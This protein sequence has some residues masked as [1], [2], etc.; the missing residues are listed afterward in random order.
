M[1]VVI[2]GGSG[3][4]GSFVSNEL[5]DRDH[6]V[7][8]FDLQE[9]EYVSDAEFRKGDVTDPADIAAAVSDADAVV[10]MVSM[11]G[12][13][14]EDD[15]VAALNV[16]V[17]GPVNVLE[18]TKNTDTR[19]IYISS[20]A[21]FGPITGEHSHP[22]YLPLQESVEKN[23]EQ[24]YGITKL[25]AEH[26]CK[27]YIRKYDSDVSIFR[28]GTTYGPY[29]GTE[30]HSISFVD[31]L[32]EQAIDGE[33]IELSGGDQRED[34]IYHADIARGLADALEAERLHYPSYH[35]GSGSLSTIRDFAD[36]LTD[37]FP[38]ASFEIE[39]GTD[40]YGGERN[41]YAFMDISRARADFG[42]DPKYSIREGLGD[43]LRRRGAI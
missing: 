32:V 15:P 22:Q 37:H 14:C 16:N 3:A 35:L 23:P 18:A 28:F 2:T 38:D 10:H 31:Q 13:A 1:D 5:L 11:L 27:S 26:Y 29:K 30:R 41:Y 24:L 7:T 36:V 4:I 25:A 33:T 21:A 20:K 6:D 19:V 9:P 42:F 12:D 17:G 43:S 40:F 8:V 39:G 34:F